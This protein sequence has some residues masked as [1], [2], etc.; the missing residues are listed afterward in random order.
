MSSQQARQRA[1][2]ELEETLKQ[3]SKETLKQYS[4]YEQLDEGKLIH[5]I[6]TLDLFR[7]LRRMEKTNI[8]HGKFLLYV[9]DKL[10]EFSKLQNDVAQLKED[11]IKFYETRGMTCPLS[12]S[13]S[14]L[15]E[16][17]KVHLSETEKEQLVR[18][19]T[20]SLREKWMREGK[21]EVRHEFKR[22][23]TIIMLILTGVTAFAATM[24]WILGLWPTGGQL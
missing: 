21:D 3:H 23:V 17:I 5:E 9:D 12:G 20:H 15:E 8:V 2:E 16:A 13:I 24:S 19:T 6:S 10:I 11:F 22:I 7:I 14:E 4:E 18:K 1:R